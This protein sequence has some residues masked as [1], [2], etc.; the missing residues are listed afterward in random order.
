MEGSSPGNAPLGRDVQRFT[1]TL[2]PLLQ[3]LGLKVPSVAFLTSPAAT[4]TRRLYG[5]RP[6]LCE[7]LPD[8]RLIPTF[9]HCRI[10]SAASFYLEAGSWCSERPRDSQTWADFYMPGV[11]MV[12]LKENMLSVTTGKYSIAF[13][14]CNSIQIYVTTKCNF[15]LMQEVFKACRK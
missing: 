7:S 4:E 9:F 8:H 13:S 3:S 10:D 2:T 14:F 1:D 6:L 15:L 11:T 12:K 5:S